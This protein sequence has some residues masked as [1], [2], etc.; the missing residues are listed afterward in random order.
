MKLRSILLIIITGMALTA[1]SGEVPRDEAAKVARNFYLQMV[2]NAESIEKEDISLT[3]DD[4]SATDFNSFYAFNVNM[5]DGFVLVSKSD[6]VKPVLAY[7]FEGKFN[8]DNMHPGQKGLLEWYNYQINFAIENKPKPVDGVAEKWQRYLN[9]KQ[10]KQL[11]NF[12]TV[13]PLL[14]VSWNQD[15][16]Y[17]AMCPSAANGINGHCPVGCVATAMSQVMKHWNYPHQG[18][19]TKWHYSYNNGGHGNIFKNFAAYNYNWKAMPLKANTLN[20]EV[21]LINYHAGIAV[22]MYWTA[23]GSGSNTSKVVSAL[24]NHFRYDPAVNLIK[25]SDYASEST[26]MNILKS[27]LNNG[28]PMVY[29]GNPSSGAGHAWNC[30]GYMS[31]EFHMNWGW[32]GSGDGY[33]TLDNLL[34]QGTIGGQQYNFKY[35]QKAVIDIYPETNFPEYCSGVKNINGFEGSFGDGS[36]NKDYENNKDCFY[37]ISHACASVVQLEFKEFDLGSGDVV[38]IYDGGSTSDSIIAT[39]DAVNPPMAY[40]TVTG[41]NETLLIQFITDGSGTGDGWYVSYT[42]ETCKTNM[43]YKETSGTVNDG[44]GP[45]DYEKSTV[46]SYIIEPQ[47][48]QQVELNFTEF[49][50]A[51][52]M[53]YLKIYEND[54]SGNLLGTF[55]ANNQPSTVIVNAP[56]AYL[57]FFADSDDSVGGGWTL[58]YNNTVSIADENNTLKGVKLYPNPASDVVNLSFNLENNSKVN[59][60]LYDLV[61]RT[62]DESEYNGK[63]EYQ[64][65]ELSRFINLPEKGIYLLDINAGGNKITKKLILTK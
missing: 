20:D 63:A 38:H 7:A 27:Q 25:K 34:S 50:L 26:Y 17:N 48:A 65:I 44:S 52:A 36:A 61:G 58:N 24:S 6:R 32:G 54:V 9:L 46:C 3:N 51:G 37:K 12:R 40:S 21:A 13:S 14:R 62:V 28:R 55:D 8:A 23:N 19:G 4:L 41:Q 47:G 60:R 5:D 15:Y 49:D 56:K 18:E 43:A 42:T 35:D 16:P 33:F 59:F 10:K 2:N 39:Y 57:Q 11:K 53:D 64:E 1:F 31:N 45:C 29:S 30:D 22:E